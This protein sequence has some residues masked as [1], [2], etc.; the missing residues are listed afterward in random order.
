[1]TNL[2]IKTQ[3]ETLAKQTRGVASIAKTRNETVKTM[4][5]EVLDY[6]KTNKEVFTKQTKKS[7]MTTFINNQGFKTSKELDNYTLRALR[8]AKVILVDGYS[9]K[10]E[11]LTLSEVEKLTKFSKSSVK[12]L[13]AISDD[14]EYVLKVK[15]LIKT[16]RIEKTT[17]VFSPSAAKKI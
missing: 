8:I 13:F 15:A 4:I 5:T 2:N 7:I 17:K 3:N 16:A 1:M 14:T 12:K 6:A 11:V 10:Y 9:V